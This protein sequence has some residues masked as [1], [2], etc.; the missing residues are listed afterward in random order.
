MI[1]TSMSLRPLLVAEIG[2]NHGGDPQKARLL[3][4]AARQ[5]GAGAVKFQAYRTELF[6]H[7]QTVYYAEL[8]QEELPFPVLADLVTLAH[9]LG[10]MA[11]LTIFGPE[12]LELALRAQAD[13]LKISS[14]DLTYHQ[15]IRQAD[16]LSLPLAISTG[17]SSE[18]EIQATLG[19]LAS[20]PL[21]LQCVSLYPAPLATT[22]L[23]VLARW[24][25]AGLRAGFSD[26][27]LTLEP[28]SAAL[29]LGAV[30]VEKHFTLQRQWPGGD[31]AISARPEDF[32]ALAELA[33]NPPP[34]AESSR[35][36]TDLENE[37]PAYWGQAHKIPQPGENP[38]LIRRWAVAA[39]SLR[40]G[41]RLRPEDVLFQRTPPSP[42]PLL[43]PAE[44]WVEREL[45]RDLAKGTPVA[46][47]DLTSSPR[48][49]YE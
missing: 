5:A 39:R 37:Q 43:G 7:P 44:P 8:A 9:D 29:R 45:L 35:F 12:G 42:T 4:Q 14:G 25:R 6:L 32:Q 40:R 1:S 46:L 22:N 20:P 13:Y 27:G 3:C 49:A 24:L 11:G 16:Q 41:H 48:P 19:L 36:F 34:P 38:T 18:T 28:A 33:Q 15:L 10:L 31:N 30:M 2:G 17:A 47:A 26:H 23:A 21:V